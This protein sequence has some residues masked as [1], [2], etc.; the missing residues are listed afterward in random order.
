MTEKVEP[1]SAATVTYR[2]PSPSVSEDHHLAQTE[3]LKAQAWLTTAQALE[4]FQTAGVTRETAMHIMGL[5]CPEQEET[6]SADPN[7]QAADRPRDW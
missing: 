3:L 5:E 2:V 1:L 7:P 6:P 4:A